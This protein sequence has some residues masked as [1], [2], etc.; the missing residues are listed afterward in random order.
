MKEKAVE[1]CGVCVFVEKTQ[2]YIHYTYI[3]MIHDHEICY[4]V[5]DTICLPKFSRTLYGFHSRSR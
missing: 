2:K 1:F 3:R 5:I 4:V